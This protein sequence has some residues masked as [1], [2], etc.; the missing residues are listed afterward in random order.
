MTN[1]DDMSLQDAIKPAIFYL[2]DIYN[3]YV[4]IVALRVLW[5][6]KQGIV[7]GVWLYAK[8]RGII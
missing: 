1:Y 7:L 5:W 6:S 2:W 4:P 8:I 3:T